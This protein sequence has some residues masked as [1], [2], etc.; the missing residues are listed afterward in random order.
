L[1]VRFTQRIAIRGINPYLLVSA[2]LAQQLRPGWRK[3]LPVRVTI[4]GKPRSPARVNLMP[5]GDG[6]FYLYLNGPLR[7]ASAT[8]VG[9]R[10]TARVSFD[11]SYRGGPTHP[12][13]S[14]LERA[15]RARPKAARAWDEFSPSRRKEILRYLA[16][17]RTAQAR[18]RNVV[19]LIAMLTRPDR[20][21]LGRP[22]RPKRA[23]SNA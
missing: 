16:G 5:A 15:L 19:K 10:V 9:D 12:V 2:K 20:E 8:A 13:P 1:V 23:A 6:S 14:S 22:R 7:E 21:F 11:A 4:D 18:E 3:P 17:L